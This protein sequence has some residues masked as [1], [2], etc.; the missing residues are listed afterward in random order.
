MI[1]RRIDHQL[2]ALETFIAIE[3]IGEPAVVEPLTPLLPTELSLIQ[4][5]CARGQVGGSTAG[6][7]RRWSGKG[8]GTGIEPAAWLAAPWRAPGGDPLG[9]VFVF[10]RRGEFFF[11]PLHFG[12]FQRLLPGLALILSPDGAEDSSDPMIGAESGLREVME[13][14]RLVARTETPVLIH[15]ETGSGKE[16]V[17]KEIHSRSSRAAEPLLRVN[18]GAIPPDL[19]DSELFGHER[20]GFTGAVSAR[21]GWF[22]RA[23]RG[24]LFLD[25]VGELPPAAQVRLLRILQDGSFEKVGGEG[26]SHVDVRIVA[27][28]HRNISALT[29]VGEFREDLWYR[30]NVFP[31]NLP[32]LRE[33]RDDI[34]PLASFFAMRTGRRLGVVPLLPSPEDFDTLGRYDWPG[35]VR[36]LAAVIERAAILAGGTRLDL[37]AAFGQLPMI[38]ADS[39]HEHPRSRGRKPFLKLDQAV[40]EH[41]EEA[42]SLCRGRIEGPRGAA[43]L[44]GVNPHTLRGKMRKLRI[45]WTQFRAAFEGD[46]EALDAAHER[47]GD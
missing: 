32:P 20:G 11:S 33:R 10:A 14:V 36:E 25:E 24:T 3:G 9:V 5:W 30:L 38:S 34:G 26:T 15:G 45:D 1:V 31:I 16:L 42:L 22:E 46:R 12:R 35:N 27:A 19:I 21:K 2:S 7:Q 29:R 18:C 8:S 28:T 6:L 39:H 4:A 17:A 47:R 23:H 44:L 13:R 43:R 37:Q 41:I 40:K